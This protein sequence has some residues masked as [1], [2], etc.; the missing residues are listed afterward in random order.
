M[1]ILLLVQRHGENTMQFFFVIHT[2][3]LSYVAMVEHMPP[4]D[5]T[6][7]M[8]RL[9]YFSY[10]DKDNTSEYIISYHYK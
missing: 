7:D 8:T 9:T 4:S 2:K 1:D 10:K 5:G 3:L 6:L